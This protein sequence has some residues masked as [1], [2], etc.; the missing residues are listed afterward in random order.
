MA[1]VEPPDITY[2]PKLDPKIIIDGK[3][4]DLQYEAVIYA[5]QRHEQRLANGNRAGYFIG[6]GTG[7]GKGRE[8][9]GVALDNWNQG[10]KR[11]L[12]LSVNNDLLP[13]AERDLTDLGAKHIPLSIV[14]KYPATEKTIDYK[15]GVLFAS[16]STL[17]S[18]AKNGVERIDQ[19]RNWL[20][21]DG[22]ILFDEG[23]LMKSAVASGMK[24]SSQRGEKGVALQEGEKSNPNWRIVYA[25]ATGA[26]DVENMGY[27]VRLG[28]W[29][30]GTSFPG[31][32]PEF[33]AAIE[34]GG[35][36][37]MEMVSRDMKA[38]GMYTAR[39][40]SFKGVEYRE[41]T[42]KLSPGQSEI[43]DVAARAWQTVM[44]N[45][46]KAIEVTNGDSRARAFAMQRFWNDQQRFFRQLLT[47]MKVP[48]A[49]SE[50]EK[51]VKAGNSVVLGLYGTGEA[52][53]KDQ[54]NKA[55]ESGAGLDD[56]D[57]SPKEVIKN[58]VEH[59]FPT[60]RYTEASDPNN[61]DKTIKV[62]V[63]DADGNPVHSKEALA[64]KAKLLKELDKLTLPDNPLDQVINHFGPNRV[65]EITGRQK[66]LVRD[67]S[68]RTHYVKRVDGV[69]ME[70]ASQH[71]MESFQEGRKR[72]AVISASASTGISLHADK[73]A[74]NQD[75]RV[76]ITLETGWSADVQMQTFGR[77]HRS[78]AASNPEYVLL[79]TNVGGEKRFLST[80]AKRLASL[81]ALTKGERKATGLTTGEDEGLSKYDFLSKYGM[82]AVKAITNRVRSDGQLMKVWRKMG[83]VKE[84][85][86]GIKVDEPD[87][88]RFLNRL[89]VLEVGEQNAMF[90]RFTENFARV[91]SQAKEMGVFDEGVT[92]V[93]GE[94][95]KL[96]EEPKV[97]STDKTTGAKTVY[98][99][100]DVNEK[101]KPVKFSAAIKI[102][103]ESQGGFFR[104]KTSGNI[105]AL[106]PAGDRTD[107]ST[108]MITKRFNVTRPS[109]AMSSVIDEFEKAK[110]ERVEASDAKSWWTDKFKADPGVRT[111]E[112]HV[113]G[114]AIMPVWQR[115]KSGG[116]E[117]AGLKV[118]RVEADDG[119][120]IVGVQIPAK[121]LAGVL[122]A[123]G[124][125]RSFKSPQAIFNGVLGGESVELV[126]GMKLQRT[127][128]KGDQAIELTGVDSYKDKEMKNLGLNHEIVSYRDRYFV[129]TDEAKGLD[130]LNKLLERYP[131]ISEGEKDVQALAAGR[132]KG[133]YGI[134]SDSLLNATGISGLESETA[135]G[136]RKHVVVN[137][138]NRVPA[139]L[140]KSLASSSYVAELSKTFDRMV[141]EI[142][143]RIKGLDERYDNTEFIGVAVTNDF[144]GA[145]IKHQDLYGQPGHDLI[146][147]NPHRIYSRVDEMKG[148]FL[149]D[150]LP[151]I[152]AAQLLDTMVHEIV[153]SATKSEGKLLEKRIEDAIN[154]LGEDR[155]A[156]AS[157]FLHL[158]TRNQSKV[159]KE[160]AKD[161]A[162]IESSITPGNPL[163]DEALTDASTELSSGRSESRVATGEGQ[164]AELPSDSRSGEQIHADTEPQR[165]GSGVNPESGAASLNLLSAGTAEFFKQDVIPSVRDVAV[166]LVKTRDTIRKI[167]APQNRTPQAKETSHIIREKAADLAQTYDRAEQALAKARKY[168]SSK[169]A[170]ENFDF[171]DRI[172]NGQPQADANLDAVAQSVRDILDSDR[173]AVQALGKG[174]LQT[175]YEDYF[176]H[177]WK[178]PKKA[179]TVFSEFYGK[180]PLE[181]AKSFLKK[182]SH[183]TFKDGLAAGLEPVA[184]NP[185]DLALAKHYEIRRYVA[186]QQ[187]LGEMKG[188]G[189]ALF[190]NASN[191]TK[192]YEVYDLAGKLFAKGVKKKQAKK[193]AKMGF[194]VVQK[195]GVPDG[196]KKIDDK[197]ATVYAPMDAEG[198]Q[199]IRGHYYAPE[200]VAQV[201]N[202]YLSPGL[203][204][205]DVYRAYMAIGNT[206]NQ[207]QLGFSAFHLGMTSID[208]VTSKVALAINQLAY[209]KPVD[210]MKSLVS[211]PLAPVANAMRGNKV[212][213]EWY[214]SGS[215]G[216]QIAAI[217]DALKSGGGR[218]RQDAFYKTEATKQMMDAFRSG[219]VPGGLLRLPFAVIENSAKPLME[220]I[221]PRQKLG[222]FADI[223]KT[224]LERLGTNATQ[225]QVR[226]VMAK[227]WDSVDNRMGQLV[228]DNLFWN[229][230]AKDLSMAST[231][232]LGWNLGTI[233]EIGGAG[234]D[235]AA[236]VG[237]MLRGKRPGVT[238]R[239]AYTMALPIVVGIMGGMLMYLFTGKRPQELKDYFYPQTGNTDENG[240]P[241]R[242][243]LPSY[244]K[245]VFAY[246]SHPATT[247]S[248]KTHPLLNLLVEMLQNEDYYGVKIRNEDDPLMQQALD[249]LQHVGKGFLPF[250][251]RGYQQEAERNSPISKRLLPFVGVTPAPTDVNRSKAERMIAKYLTEKLPKGSRT[252]E[253]YGKAKF[254]R[255]TVRR[256]R[257]GEEF[258][259]GLVEAIKNGVVTADEVREML[260]EAK[261]SPIEVRFK[262]LPLE[263][264]LKVYGVATP[265]EKKIL[266]PVLVE[267]IKNNKKT[268]SSTGANQAPSSTGFIR[269][270]PSP[271][272][273]AADT[274]KQQSSG[275]GNKSSVIA[276][277]RRPFMPGQFQRVP[278][279]M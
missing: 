72:I 154:N 13:S 31:G 135:T 138:D 28:L 19:I 244:M 58:L 195:R 159:F 246:S 36:G 264:A 190:I 87:V 245:D 169:D 269:R 115:L 277:Q 161:A 201:L 178:D 117:S 42:H 132:K 96:A 57:F 231:R 266:Q 238:Y 61:P 60:V 144:L 156:I 192:T 30:E 9:A 85:S 46:D 229:K 77:T 22:V 199:R 279:G 155:A 232:S 275:L 241:E 188:K 170:A 47:A 164:G 141:R 83:L 158:I 157:D 205:N 222:V 41:S 134:S 34:E 271:A 78:N 21:D 126:G 221:V 86:D 20:G 11:I 276:Q 67:E 133:R 200:A 153:H 183:P 82:A 51:A 173:I 273:V 267:K 76:H 127:F 71:E 1:A 208:A 151:G 207:A 15:D 39:T 219:N 163:S 14:N 260:R 32:F 103:Q 120:R 63:T 243:Q 129:P 253:E 5:G 186:A 171:I 29:G 166:G 261:E 152:Y 59:A 149:E 7:V 202:N 177:I 223:A 142:K 204:G 224:E 216:A 52:R 140:V 105:V 175:F 146:Y 92:D 125:Q 228:Y 17:V 55:I 203:R 49:I 130:V 148:Y 128:F 258:S 24:K 50:I 172:E 70:R 150:E 91:V 98:Y 167:F 139:K 3:L 43:Y 68:G 101:T 268:I 250:G 113:I 88:E 233:R 119:Q 40:L 90:D 272:T 259:S 81:G 53:T 80:I 255:E 215:Q 196:Y 110:Y 242:V 234:F 278:S 236:Q 74:K 252:K 79:S 270:A 136:A 123:V 174:K 131:A 109:G 64:M 274:P 37:A 12:W 2:K 54:V 226:E 213:Q 185:V 122:K 184:N 89:L 193:F 65:S 100:L 112:V 220:Y 121:A 38:M 94:S 111:K 168:F 25:S 237:N 95:I 35:V 10:R 239:M 191:S 124:V 198:T 118:V 257:S 218:V 6:D 206:L 116:K 84:S 181:G 104:Q 62:V 27:M 189:L 97:V 99:Q 214:A 262:R 75:R 107:P 56:L 249:E 33:K 45:F 187:I 145:H 143:G 263:Q 4:S 176:P 16:Y 256:M 217:V 147:L 211:A 182:R 254:K 18:R 106:T 114:G 137:V 69:S 44:E 227:A 265:E 66:R 251:V 48:T 165:D 162:K 235:V 247:L 23:H 93:K 108:G 179:A 248:H 230:A 160:L 209:G 212:L 73:S 197:I 240:N 102:V 26:T 225:E 180:R 194:G 8:L 210:A